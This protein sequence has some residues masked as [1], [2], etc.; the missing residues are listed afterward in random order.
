MHNIQKGLSHKYENSF[1]TTQIIIPG[2]SDVL[3]VDINESDKSN[4]LHFQEFYNTNKCNF[5]PLISNGK[6]L[7]PPTAKHE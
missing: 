6:I 1:A 2:G 7:S 4:M 5:I 3:H